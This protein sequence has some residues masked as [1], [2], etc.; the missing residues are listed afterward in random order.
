[1]SPLHMIFRSCRSL[2][3]YMPPSQAHNPSGT[4]MCCPSWNVQN[5]LMHRCLLYTVLYSMSITSSAKRRMVKRHLSRAC[6]CALV[7]AFLSGLALVLHV[8]WSGTVHVERAHA[9]GSA[10]RQQH[11]MPVQVASAA[12]TTTATATATSSQ[13]QGIYA[14][15]PAMCSS[16]TGTSAYAS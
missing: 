3:C 15:A 13:L 10:A 14:N 9:E 8:H 4:F 6:H 11:I 1:M 12:A 7:A 2:R 16:S 5:Y